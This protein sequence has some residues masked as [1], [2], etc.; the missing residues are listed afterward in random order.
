MKPGM[1]S[2]PE[3]MVER[4][5]RANFFEVCSLKQETNILI[6]KIVFYNMKLPY[7][8]HKSYANY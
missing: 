5:G 1:I 4:D 6:S 8:D 7:N 3:F 2:F